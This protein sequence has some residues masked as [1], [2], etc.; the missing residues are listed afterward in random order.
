MVFELVVVYIG[1]P[2]LMKFMHGRILTFIILMGL[3]IIYLTI[4]ITSPD[5]Q[6]A[7]L[8]F[9]RY[10][11]WKLIGIRFLIS[12][13]FILAGVYIFYREHLFFFPQHKPEQYL[14]TLVLY[15]FISVIP[16]E[17]AYR[18]Y[19]YTRF[20]PLFKKQ[21]IMVAVNGLLFSLAH[22]VY[23]NYLAI[24]LAFL[25]GIVF[26]NTW[27]K[28]RSLGVTSTEHYFYGILIF[29][30]GLGKFFK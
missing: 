27:L 18:A 13:I 16:Q 10:K 5:F 12:A 3:G 29:S 19:F 14:L 11:G 17:I 4:L 22:I 1:F 26:S 7:N 20:A 8:W 2:V 30:I 9:R 6:N 24:I 25:G 15:P 23:N 28:S 21:W